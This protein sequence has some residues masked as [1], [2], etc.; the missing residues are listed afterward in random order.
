MVHMG[1]P[2]D[3][4]AFGDCSDGPVRGPVTVPA[5][6]RNPFRRGEAQGWIFRIEG[7]RLTTCAKPEP[8]G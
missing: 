4:R 5:A 7:S 6:S 3:V 2:E 1:A 8:A